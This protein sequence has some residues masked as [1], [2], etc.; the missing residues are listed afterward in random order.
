M[1]ADR[2]MVQ[3]EAEAAA[4][5]AATLLSASAAAAGGGGSGGSRRNPVAVLQLSTRQDVFLLDLPALAVRVFGPNFPHFCPLNP[6]PN[7]P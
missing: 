7:F 3:A 2:D 1:G 5:M 4:D 6:A